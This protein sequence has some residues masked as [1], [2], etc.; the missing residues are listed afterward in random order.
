MNNFK[1]WYTTCRQM[2]QNHA[3][4]NKGKNKKKIRFRSVT[5]LGQNRITSQTLNRIGTV[6]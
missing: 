6:F 1:K 4:H 2:Q 5:V 3:R